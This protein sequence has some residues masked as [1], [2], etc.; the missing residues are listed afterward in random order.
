MSQNARGT[1]RLVEF[2]AFVTMD[3]AEVRIPAHIFEGDAAG[4]TVYVG[5]ATHGNELQGVEICRR[6]AQEL[7]PKSLQGKLIVVPVQN[8]MAFKHRVRLNPI[9]GKDLDRLYPGMP[10]GTATERLAHTLYSK[11]ASTADV[12]ID[13][14]SGGIGS[15]NIPHIYVPSKKPTRTEHTSLELAKAFGADVLIH[16]EPSVDYHFDLEHLSPY[17]CNSHG[18]AGLYPEMGEGGRVSEHYVEFG[19]RGVKN[20]LRKLG[21]LTGAVEEQGRQKVATRTSVTQTKTSGILLRRYE[22][23]QEVRKGEVMAEVVGVFGGR[24]EILA[25]TDGTIHWT[26]TFGNIGAGEHVAWLAHN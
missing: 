6:L 24:E 13:L 16:T 15:M 23:G 8:P 1:R 14:H 7:D 18:A 20:V 10:D 21:M 5:A 9:D 17:C 22:L 25:P 2:P 3:G 26:V 19:L 11:L 12:V 4:P